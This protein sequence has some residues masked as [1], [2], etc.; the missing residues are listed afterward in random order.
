MNLTL[1]KNTG[2]TFPAAYTLGSRVSNPV[3]ECCAIARII[4]FFYAQIMVGVR[5]GRKPAGFNSNAPSGIR[6]C[7]HP[8]PLFRIIGDGFLNIRSYTMNKIPFFQVCEKT[9]KYQASRKLTEAQIIKAAKKLIDGRVS[10]GAEITNPAIARDYLITHFASHTAEEFACLFMDA[11]N[12]LLKIETLFKGTVNAAAVY[13]R[14]IIRRCLELNA[15][16]VIFA[17]N[18][19]SGRIEPSQADIDLGR[20]LITALKH[21]EVA[22]QDNFIVA[23]AE[24]FS[25]MEQNGS[26]EAAA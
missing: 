19:P 5:R 8:S 7:V 16:A 24:A 14:E 17:H 10:R 6:T 1:T 23:G 9:Q 13:P 15:T 20:T 22:V 12:K 3:N 18:H 25:Y 11:G 26:M 21:I 2:Y 4:A